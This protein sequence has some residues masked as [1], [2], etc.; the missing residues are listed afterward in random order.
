MKSRI[1]IDEISKFFDIDANNLSSV[2]LDANKES[3]QFELVIY[4]YDDADRAI[5]DRR[6]MRVKHTM[7]IAVVD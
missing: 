6:G 4:A 3:L 1:T 2:H 5:K 7:R